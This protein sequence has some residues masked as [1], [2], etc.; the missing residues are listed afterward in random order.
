MY[1]RDLSPHRD[2][3]PGLLVAVFTEFTPLCL[4]ATYTVTILS[5]T[6]VSSITTVE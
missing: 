5:S 4:T 3:M 6:T 2:Y 1:I